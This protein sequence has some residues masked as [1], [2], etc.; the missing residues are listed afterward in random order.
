MTSYIRK[1]IGDNNKNILVG[2]RIQTDI[3][4][5]KK[6]G[7]ETV[8]VCSGEFKKDTEINYNLENTQIHNTL[9][10]FLLTI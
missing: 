1:I 5:G 6:I 4:I 2:D 7:A 8:I 9:T 3:A 10:D